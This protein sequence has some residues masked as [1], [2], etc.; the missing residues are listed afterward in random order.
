MELATHLTGRH[1]TTTL[2]PLS[3]RE[4]I[5]AEESE[6]PESE[7][8]RKFQEYVIQGGCPEPYI[9]GLD[10]REYLAQ[11]FESTIYKDI[12]KRYRIRKLRTIE[13]LATYLLSNIAKPFSFNRL[14]RMLEDESVHTIKK[15]LNHLEEAFRL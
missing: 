9:K 8:K 1:L 5:S 12:V 13:D 7:K 4:I 10:Y 6:I 2:L 15:Y 11:L 3:F 14:S